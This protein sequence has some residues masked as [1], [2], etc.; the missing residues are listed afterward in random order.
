MKIVEEPRLFSCVLGFTRKEHV[1]FEQ[2]N[3]NFLIL[4]QEVYPKVVFKGHFVYQVSKVVVIST[5]TGKKNSKL[6]TI[7]KKVKKSKITK[8]RQI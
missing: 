3:Q 5:R 4:A 7:F 1:N 8:R 6:T 2:E